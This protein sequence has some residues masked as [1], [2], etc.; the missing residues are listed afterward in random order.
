M[1]TLATRASDPT[2]GRSLV[3]IYGVALVLV[4]PLVLFASSGVDDTFITY[5]AARAL[6]S[7]GHIVNWN[8]D[9]IEQSSS[10][11]LV[12]WLAALYKLTHVELTTLGALTSIAFG[13]A[14]FIVVARLAQRAAQSTAAHVVL[15]TGCAFP[16][17]LWCY[18]GMEQTAY[19]FL[20]ASYFVLLD[21]LT[22]TP[23]STPLLLAHAL[24]TTALVLVRP[25][26][27]VLLAAVLVGLLVL[28]LLGRVVPATRRAVLASLVLLVVVTL[29]VMMWR[30]AVFGLSFPLPVLAKTEAL[31]AD[32]LRE[33]L[34]YLTS[35]P[36][37]LIVA[38]ATV[39]G[40]AGVGV[41]CARGRIPVALALSALFAAGQL[42]FVIA[43]GGDWIPGGRFLVPLVPFAFIC[44]CAVLERRRVVLTAV[45]GLVCALELYACAKGARRT[46]GQSLWARTTV[47][48]DVLR[49]VPWFVRYNRTYL[50][51]L[52]FEKQLEPLVDR[53]FA[54]TH[55]PVVVLTEHAGGVHY[56]LAADRRA[57]VRL[58]DR[59]AITTR[60][61]LE[62]EVSK[63]LPRY[64]V[65]LDVTYDFVIA[66]ERAL[67]DR[68]GIPRADII[69]DLEFEAPPSTA[70]K[71]VIANDYRLAAHQGPVDR[72]DGLSESALVTG[73]D[74]PAVADLVPAIP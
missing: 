54:A 11:F 53:I 33:G 60:D 9:A 32:R 40:V 41:A 45:T 38:A 30:R 20:L 56:W 37:S 21:E 61:F 34:R 48:K 57:K 29:A 15:L 64:Q 35:G 63:Y 3:W 66:N 19:V 13:C 24:V 39:L 26:A 46:P 12:L 10:L 72:P 14:S 51:D 68:C 2:A 67:K 71:D 65:G 44:C 73:A 1:S 7:T 58:L 18:S 6:A 23:R 43:V 55:R 49:S 62:C 69:H 17:V 4:C 5:G 50:R 36:A 28:A 25:E 47:S 59:H 52:L 8:G 22:S 31:S 74:W 16:F 27:F 70:W 42:G